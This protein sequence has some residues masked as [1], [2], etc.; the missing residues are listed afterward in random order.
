MA[1]TIAQLL[2]ELGVNTAFLKEG[3][4]KATYMAKAFAKDVKDAV[5]EAQEGVKNLG[6]AFADLASGNVEGAIDKVADT[7]KNLTAELGEAGG[8]A[9]T[10]VAA[11]FAVGAGATALA[12]HGAEAAARLEDLSHATGMS[13]EALSVL[14]DVAKTKGVDMESMAKSLERMERSA[15]QAAQ[16][17]PKAKNAYVDLGIAVTDAEGRMKSAQ[18]LFDEV[19]TKFQKMPDG[20]EK[21]AE[22][23]KIFGRAG[24]NMI[25]LLDQGGAHIEELK[26]H[27]EALNAVTSGATAQASEQLKEN[28]TVLGAAFQG[29]Q[30]E[31]TADLVPALNVVAKN[32]IEFF[33]NNQSEIKAFVD[34]IS[35]VAKV[36]LNVFQIVGEIFSLIYRIFITAVDEL[37][38]FG[39]AVGKMY[40]DVSSH[41]WSNIWTDLKGSGKQAADELKYNFDEA[42]AS[43]EKTGA[44]MVGVTTATLPKAKTEQGPEG[45]AVAGKEIDLTFIEKQVG[46]LEAQAAKE[47]ELAKAIGRVSASHIDA[48]A[49]AEMHALSEKLVTE[50]MSKGLSRGD[51]EKAVGTYTARIKEAA[52]WVATFQAAIGSQDAID[53][54]DEKIKQSIAS[55]QGQAVAMS[56]ADREFAKN[57]ATLTP[58]RNNLAELQKEYDKLATNPGH[59][60]K[61]MAELAEAIQR[62]NDELAKEVDNVKTLDK[63]WQDAQFAKKLQDINLQTQQLADENAAIQSGDPFGKQKAQLDRFIADMKV[64]TEEAKKLHAA[65]DAQDK[66]T[67]ISGALGQSKKAGYDPA[68]LAQLRAERDALASLNLP[69]QA[70]KLTLSQINAEIAD[71][72]AKM[73]GLG[74]QAH[75]A[76]ADFSKTV[77]EANQH[78]FKDLID[79]GLKGITDNFANMVATGKAS[80]GSLITSMETMLLKSSINTILNSI[81]KSIGNALSDKGGFLGGLGGLFGGGH[82]AGGSVVPGMTYLTG[83]HGPELLQVD[84]PGRIYPNGSGPAAGGPPVI[85]QQFNIQT[86]DASSF[87]KSK[88]QIMGEM[89]RDSAYAHARFRS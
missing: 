62:Q 69:A 85:N 74:A 46:Q 44:A 23:M 32:L 25:A 5:G 67:V 84:Q 33:E 56:A 49:A 71:Q 34:G 87:H 50:A 4:D 15:L 80:W 68:A 36:T 70:Y 37:Q 52:T 10:L 45:N 61:R 66:Q 7:V 81:F 11:F 31:L 42:I 54:F 43:I 6:S 14:G 82:A 58:L 47:E 12:V 73:G 26:G 88:R 8:V 41:K 16:A 86:P 30:N 65:L 21:T 3:F 76:F 19:S 39:S 22:A 28:M 89:Y 20:P 29:V 1:N 53:K 13:V 64:G 27:F 79:T 38:V 55:L 63:A 51:A 24:A 35:E 78:L 75:A 17:G 2:V 40:E 18:Q 83:E 72:E 59:D 57:D 60:P 9:G 48:K 77:E